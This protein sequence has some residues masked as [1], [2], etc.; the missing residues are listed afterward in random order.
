MIC[1]VIGG[2]VVLVIAAG[3]SCNERN[4]A[5]GY[6]EKKKNE[7]EFPD[8]D[9]HVLPFFYD[10]WGLRYHSLNAAATAVRLVRSSE[11]LRWPKPRTTPSS[12]SA[13]PQ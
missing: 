9:R 2:V 12:A 11:S 5:G 3:N 8:A 6:D 10:P 7:C 4:D 13:P 1:G